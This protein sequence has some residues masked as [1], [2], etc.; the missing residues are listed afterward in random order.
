MDRLLFWSGVCIY[1]HRRSGFVILGG[2][3]QSNCIKYYSN[4]FSQCIKHFTNQGRG[5]TRLD[6][7]V[8]NCCPAHMRILLW[9]LKFEQNLNNGFMICSV[10]VEQTTCTDAGKYQVKARSPFVCSWMFLNHI[11]NY[12]NSASKFLSHALRDN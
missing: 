3:A 4:E 11:S 12:S 9:I 7:V 5:E 1:M 6:Y 2:G 10:K 8:K